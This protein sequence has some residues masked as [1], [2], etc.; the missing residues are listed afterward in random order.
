MPRSARIVIPGL[1]HHVTQRGNNKQDIFLN[2]KDYLNYLKLLRLYS[3][4]NNLAILGYCLMPNH[5]HL[6]CVPEQKDS[7]ARAIGNTHLRYAQIFNEI[8][9]R[10]GHL[11]QGRYYSC[12]LDKTHLIAALQYVEMNPV[13][14]GLVKSAKDYIW[15][16]APVHLGL[17]DDRGILNLNWWQR[18]YDYKSWSEL[19]SVEQDIQIAETIREHTQKGKPLGSDKFIEKINSKLKG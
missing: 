18:N 16:S 3:I 2:S 14:A 1:P 10:N 7:L 11:W 12:V 6:I 8:T 9:N 4:E 17:T 15:S 5:V 13:R 19:L